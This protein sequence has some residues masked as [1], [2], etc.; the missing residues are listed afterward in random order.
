MPVKYPNQRC[1]D[2]VETYPVYSE[3]HIP[4]MVK[5]REDGRTKAANQF[6]DLKK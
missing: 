2:C 4:I 3:K 6:C 1:V 5:C